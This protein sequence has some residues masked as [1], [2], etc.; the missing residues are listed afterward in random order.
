MRPRRLTLRSIRAYEHLQIDVPQGMALLFGENGAGKTTVLEALSYLSTTRSFRSV[1][2]S[3]MIQEGA[4][5]GGISADFGGGA[6]VR[7]V[8][9]RVGGR[10]LYRDGR[11]IRS[12]GEFVAGF[13]TVVLAP[14]HQRLVDGAGEER[15]R[16]LD[17]ILFN[18][19]PAYLETVRRYAR[20]VRQKQALLRERIPW[21]GF[22]NRVGPW[23]EELA[24]YGEEIR[25]RRR[26]LTGRLAGRL[27]E[28]HVRLAPRGGEAEIS[29]DE[30]QEPLAEG[31]SRALKKEHAAARALVG[32]HRDDLAILLRGLPVAEVGSQGERSSVLM[33]LK[34]AELA[35]IEEGV[36]APPHLLLD[37]LGAT[38]DAERRSHLL[39][40]LAAGGY[41]ALLT[42]ADESVRGTAEAAGARVY[43]K[44]IE[45]LPGGFSIA[46]WGAA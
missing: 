39:R 13:P 31:L 21:G 35:E 5:S 17:R 14:E 42:T 15:R 36:G 1:R 26:A 44:K 25:I 45:P 11:H 38:L 4:E 27:R 28:E 8:E 6:G 10:T 30:P 24:V 46:T 19:E 9:L 20:A 40:L 7:S 29:Y 3:R 18:L 41:G 23:N 43:L 33:A 34:L 12:A 2:A 16:F 37:D 32:P 22:E